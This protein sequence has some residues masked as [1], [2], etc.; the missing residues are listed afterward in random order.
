MPAPFLA[1]SRALVWIAL[2]PPAA[3]AQA[4]IVRTYELET[5]GLHHVKVD[6]RVVSARGMPLADIGVSLQPDGGVSGVVYRET[7][8]DGQGRFQF[9]DVSSASDLTGVVDPPPEWIPATFT[10]THADGGE[11]HAGDIQ[12]RANTTLR[13]ALET[14][15]GI[16]FSGDPGTVNVDLAPKGTPRTNSPQVYDHGVFTIDYITYREAEL[17]VSFHGKYY[18][19]PLRFEPGQRDRFVVARMPGSKKDDDKLAILEMLRPM[20]P[21]SR[22]T[23]VGVVRAP[24]GSPLEGAVVTVLGGVGFNG[25]GQTSVTGPDGHY[26]YVEP[27]GKPSYTSVGL[28]GEDAWTSE[29]TVVNDIRIANAIPLK[30]AADAPPASAA[31][32]LRVRWWHDALGWLPLS[33]LK[34]WVA[35]GT[36]EPARKL[37]ADSYASLVADL[38]GYF[39]IAIRLKLPEAGDPAQ[40]LEHRFRFTDSPVRTL[41]VRSLGKPLA[42]ATVDLVRVDGQEELA[43]NLLATYTTA[44]DGRLQLAGAPVGVYEVFV[45]APGHAPAHA[46][47]NPGAPLRVA[48]APANVVLEVE[49]AVRGQLVGVRPAGSSNT[50]AVARVA[51]TPVAFRLAPGNYEVTAMEGSGR[52]AGALHVTLTAGRGAHVSLA[53]PKLPEV[54]LEFPDGSHEW[55]A[56]AWRVI[57]GASPADPPQPDGDPATAHAGIGA[58]AATLHLSESGWY[59]VGVQRSGTRFELQRTIEAVGGSLMVLKVPAGNAS[60]TGNAG[61]AITPVLAR[62]PGKKAVGL[63][64]ASADA[65]GW[66]VEVLPLELQPDNG[67]RIDGLPAGR[68]YAWQHVYAELGQADTR[69]EGYSDECGKHVRGGVAVALATGRS[70]ALKDLAAV[71]NA[72]VAVRIVDGGGQPVSHATVFVRHWFPEIPRAEGMLNL[73]PA[74]SRSLIVPVVGGIAKV[75][76]VRAGRLEFELLL[77]TGRVYSMAGEVAP[78]RPLEIRLPKEAR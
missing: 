26:T 76:D 19:A 73:A 5:S 12:L 35:P 24:D 78:G 43:S 10:L 62:E 28:V 72:A 22:P 41:L 1:A 58:Q 65:D 71:P 53:A 75:P 7:R 30:L 14:A 66:D 33:R 34:T 67:F 2:L 37:V 11:S 36:P 64:L 51:S 6:G 29:E 69:F 59:L 15:Q 16:L 50:V 21:P 63:R 56:T 31:A 57:D 4:R 74:A 8:T 47:W 18:T 39:P 49:G 27:R 13:V 20:D 23:R 68:Y 45:Y 54:R 77:D 61:T 40:T 44:A 38:P 25:L 46:I 42:G 3:W 55:Q 48:L 17:A 70:E 9:A 32:P 52:L 60:L